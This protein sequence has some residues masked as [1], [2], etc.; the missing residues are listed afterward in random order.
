MASPHSQGLSS[1]HS[2]MLKWMGRFVAFSAADIFGYVV[3]GCS[4]PWL[5]QSICGEWA[6]AALVRQAAIPRAK[7]RQMAHSARLQRFVRSP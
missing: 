1:P 7:H 3:L 6:A 4:K 5:H 2:H